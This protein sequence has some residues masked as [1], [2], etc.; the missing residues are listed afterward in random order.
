MY[1]GVMFC[2]CLVFFLCFV[3]CLLKITNRFNFHCKSIY[4]TAKILNFNSKISKCK[5]T[6][7][8]STQNSW[9]KFVYTRESVPRMLLLIITSCKKPL[10]A[11]FRNFPSTTHIHK[12]ISRTN[13]TKK[14]QTN[15][16]KTL[17]QHTYITIIFRLGSEHTL[18]WDT[19]LL[20]DCVLSW[21]DINLRYIVVFSLVAK[22]IVI[23]DICYCDLR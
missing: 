20:I 5:H 6:L 18:I 14:N 16:N 12:F 17:H 7:R 3:C 11:D 4:M 10:M 15:N 8:M 13:K 9:F 2:C 22:Q 1:A 19:W 21:V 23:W